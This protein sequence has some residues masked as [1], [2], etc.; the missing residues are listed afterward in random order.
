MYK[1]ADTV[2]LMLNVNTGR[3][4]QAQLFEQVRAMIIEGQLSSGT[5][6]P[7]TRALSEQLGVSRNTVVLAYDRL[8]AEGYIESKRS[9]GTFVSEAIPD[10]GGVADVAV[11]AAQQSNDK[12]ISGSGNGQVID[13]A[14]G[15]VSAFARDGVADESALEQAS[16][17]VAALGNDELT[18]R[19]ASAV[20]AS[21]VH[22]IENLTSGKGRFDAALADFP[23]DILADISFSHSDAQNKKN[24][25]TGVELDFR[26]GVPD[27]EALPLRTWRR[28]I[29][30]LLLQYDD[31]FETYPDLQGAY[32]LRRAIADHLGPAR[33]ILSRAEDVII[34]SSA[35][36]GR[37][38]LCELL[39]RNGGTAVMESP[40]PSGIAQLFSYYKADVY[41]AEV[42]QDGMV[43][44][45]LPSLN[46]QD[47]PSGL[48]Y[49]TPSHHFPLGMGMTL[50]RRIQ[51]LEWAVKNNALIVED[52]S[53]SDFRY[54][55]SPL[56]ALK[57]LDTQGGTLVA[58]PSGSQGSV[59]YLGSF[60]KSMG[61]QVGY[62][63]VPQDL[64]KPLT[65][66]MA[67]SRSGPSWLE[68]L[69]MAEFL[70]NGAYD[71][72]LRKL[73][74]KCME[75][76]D[77]LI[78]QLQH[79]FGDVVLSG[80]EGG[81]HLIWHLP[82]SLGK[83][84]DVAAKMKLY[85]N[86]GLYTVTTGGSYIVDGKGADD[87]A[88]VFGYSSLS[89]NEI[90]DGVQRLALQLKQNKTGELK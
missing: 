72:H 7:A 80:I 1:A 79:H 53:T 10:R 49:V 36:E 67:L 2:A 84:E 88:L 38:L 14:T 26:P 41:G 74:K 40:G 71:R 78:E 89:L 35:Q 23:A 77:L 56:T 63:V 28:I 5:P 12:T 24:D 60:M 52:E 48:A 43:V 16:G 15:D 27:S 39:L 69:A 33:G 46:S 57:G 50:A 90:T 34:V 31:Y 65:A 4:L 18:A 54:G 45:D 20:E 70:D 59:I 11:I 17:T 86:V 3:P 30:R 87:Q 37:S 61:V 13:L 85:H 55:G 19:A 75:K 44:K 76:R 62:L 68:Q 42:D 83:A 6:L 47:G 32:D 9:I 21:A 25:S 29:N 66:L 58:T 73:R 82:E 8:L 22:S 51:L 64:V 81:L